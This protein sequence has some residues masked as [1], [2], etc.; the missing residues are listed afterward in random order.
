[1]FIATKTVTVY[2]PNGKK[3][4]LVKDTDIKAGTYNKLNKGQRAKYTA[5][6]PSQLARRI[7]NRR[8]VLDQLGIFK[9]S[10]CGV[11]VYC[12]ITFVQCHK[13]IY[14]TFYKHI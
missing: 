6:K 2:L 3:L 10:F 8:A 1:M 7:P 12:V 5:P 13:H 9:T 11:V 14:Q 4:N